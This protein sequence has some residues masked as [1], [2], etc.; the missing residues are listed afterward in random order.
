M[1]RAIT[2][3]SKREENKYYKPPPPGDK[4]TVQMLYSEQIFANF[5]L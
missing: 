2:Y 4:E 1:N 3:P 5:A